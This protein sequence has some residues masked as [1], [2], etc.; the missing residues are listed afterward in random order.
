MLPPESSIQDAF[1]GIEHW[2]KVIPVGTKYDIS[3][4]GT[5]V[6]L[7]ATWMNPLVLAAGVSLLSFDKFLNPFEYMD[8]ITRTNKNVVPMLIGLTFNETPNG[9]HVNALL[10]G[11][12]DKG[13]GDYRS[14]KTHL[15]TRNGVPDRAFDRYLTEQ[16][17][18]P[19]PKHELR[20]LEEIVPEAQQGP[21]QNCPSCN[22]EISISGI[23]RPD[24]F[25]VCPKCFKKFKP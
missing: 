21:T 3:V 7:L 20:K 12:I 2:M 13:M 5:Q 6:Q 8:F 14:L 19:S 23:I 16:I 18:K 25:V 4:K 10:L 1:D 15:L 11:A 9:V 17:K 24:G 22:S